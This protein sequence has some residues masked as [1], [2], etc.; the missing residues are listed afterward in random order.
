MRNPL[1]TAGLAALV[2]VSV[3][4]QGQGWAQS[5][6]GAQQAPDSG[7]PAAAVDAQTVDHQVIVAPLTSV[8][9]DMNTLVDKMRNDP[10]EAVWAVGPDRSASQNTL[11]LLA[12]AL[13]VDATKLI[14]KVFPD[15]GE[16]ANGIA[17]GQ[18]DIAMLPLS[19]V[20]GRAEDGDVRIL[21]IAS[22]TP[23]QGLPVPT[24]REQGIDVVTQP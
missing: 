18:A 12:Q 21:A 7:G 11:G 23:L 5:A 2:L 19:A 13:G 16:I 17:G 8:Y 14:L 22:D 15:E 24:L 20:A 10:T 9:R 3:P 4:P 1:L 6:T